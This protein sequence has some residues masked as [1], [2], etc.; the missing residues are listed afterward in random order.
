MRFTVHRARPR[1]IVVDE[2]VTREECEELLEEAAALFPQTHEGE[3]LS[4][5]QIAKDTF[6]KRNRNIWLDVHYA[7][8]AQSRIMSVMHARLFGDDVRNAIRELDDLL[9]ENALYAN[10][11][12]TLLSIYGDGDFYGEHVDEYPGIAANLLLGRTPVPFSG[13]AFYLGANDGFDAFKPC[14]FTKIP[15]SPGR[16]ILFPTKARHFVELVHVGSSDVRDHRIS[17]QYWPSFVTRS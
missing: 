16:L 12:A 1:H 6:K 4:G 17:V 7:D 13:G 9:F 10:R 11:D 5:A 8:K 3:V 15:F 2:F 14:R